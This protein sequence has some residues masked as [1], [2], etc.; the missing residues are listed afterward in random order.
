MNK[1]VVF[2]NTGTLLNASI[3]LKDLATGNLSIGYSP[4]VG[5]KLKKSA[6]IYIQISGNDLI[7]FDESL[8]VFDLFNSGIDF[9]INLSPVKISKQEVF[10]IV[11]NDPV[12]LKDINDCIRCLN[13]Y[14]GHIDIYSGITIIL[15]LES[16]KI[17]YTSVVGGCLFD[18]VV[19]CIFELQNMGVEVFI[20]SGDSKPALM[21][22]AHLVNIYEENVFANC[23]DYDKANLVSNLKDFGYTV[24]MVGD[25]HND[26]KAFMESDFAILINN[27]NNEALVNYVDRVVGC[28]NDVLKI[29]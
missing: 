21:K 27:G 15:N 24:T 25:G 7:N 23:K 3:S 20:A 11:R 26:V 2:D 16:R 14:L 28:V 10:D 6:I 18:G 9:D 13:A 19:E 12:T 8:R 5:E 22:L 29:V 17:E 4:E 1:A